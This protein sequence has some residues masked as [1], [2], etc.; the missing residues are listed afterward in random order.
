M[1]GGGRSND[2]PRPAL[3]THPPTTPTVQRLEKAKEKRLN[4]GEIGE[5]SKHLMEFYDCAFDYLRAR[6]KLMVKLSNKLKQS[7][8]IF[9]CI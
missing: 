1:G 7:L 2:P 5:N 6:E 9:L 3:P 4:M 8:V